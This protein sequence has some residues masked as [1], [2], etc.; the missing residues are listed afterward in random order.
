MTDEGDAPAV[1]E[2]VM[3]YHRIVARSWLDPTLRDRLQGDP[4][5]ALGVNRLTP[6]ETLAVS[7]FLDDDVE[8]PLPDELGPAE[9]AFAMSRPRLASYIMVRAEPADP[10]GQEVLHFVS[11]RR[12]IAV[13]GHRLGSF[14]Q[15]ALP[16]LDGRHTVE[17]IESA[18]VDLF[19]GDELRR[20]LQVLASHGLLQ[21]ADT[22][23]IDET[24]RRRLAP[25]LNLFDELGL[26][27][28]VAQAA[29]SRATVS[30]V[31]LSGAGAAAA[32]ALAGAQVGRL[33]CIDAYAVSPVDPALAAAFPAESV[34]R[35][36]AHA[37]AE[38][39]K[40]IAP[41]VDVSSC[42]APLD[43]DEDVLEQV[44]GSDLVLCC[45]D[46]GLASLTYKV[47]RACLRAG[48]TWIACSVTGFE[49]VVGPTVVPYETACYL[50]YQMREAACAERP[51]DALAHLE[52][53]DA[54]KSD[55]SGVRENTGFGAGAIGNLVALE[56]FRQLSGIGAANVGSIVVL[57]LLTLT[58]TRHVVVRKPDC[59][60]CAQ[61]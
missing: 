60:A 59:P 20:G 54:R 44:A 29:L 15:V 50:C 52:F 2:E 13:K 36:R 21:D 4:A 48:I 41:E 11:S 17:A 32:L 12:A 7:R 26:D 28:A 14:H 19:R 42:V 23:A 6:A 3:A 31:G 49:G 43:S 35:P 25:Q 33:R 61:R 56:A 30:V 46:P 40:A 1:R 51:E 57:D 16:L 18:C 8:E 37:V 38:A 34:G 5:T 58:T 47:N 53:L 10:S 9:P 45:V 22:D 24:T 39:V 55:D 27:A